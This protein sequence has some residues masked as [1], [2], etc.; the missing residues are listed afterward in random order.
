MCSSD[1]S[2]SSVIQKEAVEP[3]NGEASGPH[4]EI[5]F[6]THL[7]TESALQQA[8]TRIREL[9]VIDAIGSVIRVES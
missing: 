4:A 7:A 8:I 5:V 2:L 6:M 1:L 9:T 3:L